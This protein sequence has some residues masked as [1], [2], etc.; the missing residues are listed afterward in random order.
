MQE[1]ARRAQMDALKAA[2]ADT[3]EGE[4][5]HIIAQFE[6]DVY[7]MQAGLKEQRDNQRDK[8]LAKMEAR[9]RMK[10]EDVKETTVTKEMERITESQVRTLANL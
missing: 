3:S 9:K 5:R 10:E 4:R 7:G 2:L 6:G 8:M 1:E